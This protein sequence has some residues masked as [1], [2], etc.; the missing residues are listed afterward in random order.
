MKIWIYMICAFVLIFS[1]SPASAFLMS[2]SNARLYEGDVDNATRTYI[3]DMGSWTPTDIAYDGSTVYAVSFTN[4]YTFD[5]DT[6]STTNVG[7]HGQSGMNALVYDYADEILYGA[8]YNGEFGS[9]T[10]GGTYTE[11]GDFGQW[12]S[13]GR[14]RDITSSGDLAI[15]YSDGTMYASV[16]VDGRSNDYLASINVSTG[17]ATI[18]GSFGYDLMYGLFF[19]NSQLYGLDDEGRLFEV[20]TSDGSTTYIRDYAQ[21]G[22]YGAAGSDPYVIPEPATVVLLISGLAGLGFFRKK[23][24]K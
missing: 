22:Y 12:Y 2:R 6:G 24:R 14:W 21:S 20:D 17:A 19:E 4:L 11:I 1:A 5:P 18:I 8:S 7:A 15:D 23:R 13:G 16:N 9:L 10:T 3:D